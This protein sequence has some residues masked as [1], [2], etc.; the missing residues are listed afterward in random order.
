V[1]ASTISAFIIGLAIGLVAL[2]LG[3]WVF[4]DHTGGKLWF[5]WI[6]PLLAIGFFATMAQL[7]VGYWAKVGKLETK[8]RPRK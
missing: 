6:A 4:A 8:G 1:R 3:I 5:Y 7:A 2:V